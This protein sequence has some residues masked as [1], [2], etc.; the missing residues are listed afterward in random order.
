[1]FKRFMTKQDQANEEFRQQH[2][3]IEKAIKQMKGMVDN[4]VNHT[5]MLETQNCAGRELIVEASRKVS[6]TTRDKTP[7]NII[8]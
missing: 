6:R 8:M 5:K 7:L 3:T 1:M 4:L 2:A